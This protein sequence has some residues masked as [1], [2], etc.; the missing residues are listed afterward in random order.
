[1]FLH[2][3]P[4]L[5]WSNRSSSTH[6][7]PRTLSTT[8]TPGE[9]IAGSNSTSFPVRHLASYANSVFFCAAVQGGEGAEPSGGLRFSSAVRLLGRTQ[10]TA[11]EFHTRVASP[12]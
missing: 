11:G 1:M 12:S 2:L 10:P 7:W 9:S 8:C 3:K 5:Y 4:L 6:S